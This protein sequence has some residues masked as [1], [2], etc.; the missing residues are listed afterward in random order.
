MG[1]LSIWHWLIVLGALA[2]AAGGVAA[3]I[4]LLAHAMRGG[5]RTGTPAEARLR[6]LADLHAKGLIEQDE[7]RRRRAAIVDGL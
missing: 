4:A 5:R 7:Y 3:L 1:G 2:L 6:A